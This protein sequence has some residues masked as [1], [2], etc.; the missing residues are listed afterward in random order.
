MEKTSNEMKFTRCQLPLQL[1]FAGTVH[2]SQGMTLQRSVLDYRTK[3]WEH[4]QLYVVLSRAKSPVDLCIVLPGDTDDFAFTRNLIKR[5]PLPDN[6]VDAPED[7]IDCVPSLDDDAVEIFDPCPDEIPFNVQIM[8]RVLED[9]QVL[10]FNCLGDIVPQSYISGPSVPVATLLRRVLQTCCAKFVSV[11]DERL[12][13]HMKQQFMN[14]LFETRIL[15][16]RILVID[17]VYRQCRI[18]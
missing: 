2:R 3:F 16:S 12:P 5:S 10:R 17:R 6:Y 1:I 7:Q 18:P 13:F 8:S 4:G 15:L 14:S 9:R 11:I